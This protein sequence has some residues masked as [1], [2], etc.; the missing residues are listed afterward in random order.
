MIWVHSPQDPIGSNQPYTLTDSTISNAKVYVGVDK[1]GETWTYV[2]VQTPTDQLSGTISISD[3][4]KTLIW[5]G[6][7]T[8]DEH[9][10]KNS[11]QV[12]A[13]VQAGTGSLQVNNLSYDINANA[14][15]EGTSGNDTFALGDAG[16]TTVIGNGGTDTAVFSGAYSAYQIQNSGSGILITNGGNIST[17][18]VL[19]GITFIQFSNGTYNVA[20]ST[21]ASK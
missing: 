19:E 17:L 18:D 16:S 8:G 10:A 5:D 7:L 21:F 13:E 14:T 4:L 1:W 2:S 9:L 15:I 11:I 6:V 12:G 20:T 3:L